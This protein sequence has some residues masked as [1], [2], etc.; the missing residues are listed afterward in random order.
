MVKEGLA[1]IDDPPR[2]TRHYWFP[3]FF[4]DLSNAASWEILT[5][6]SVIYDMLIVHWRRN[7]ASHQPWTKF[8]LDPQRLQHRNPAWNFSVFYWNGS[9]RYPVIPGWIYSLVLYTWITLKLRIMDTLNNN[10][11]HHGQITPF[12]TDL[13]QFQFRNV[14]RLDEYL[15][16]LW[17]SSIT[18]FLNVPFN[19][20]NGFP[21]FI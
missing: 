9:Y 19:G 12:V 4:T 15:D 17:T 3:A 10:P 6:F 11:L 8:C 2:G 18:D 13:F 16:N 20:D 21:L 5:V 7:D 1:W 14:H